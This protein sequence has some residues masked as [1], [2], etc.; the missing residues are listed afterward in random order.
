MSN[1]ARLAT[2][3]FNRYRP[4]HAA[5]GRSGHQSASYDIF[6]PSEA[7]KL[8][9][10]LS[11]RPADAPSPH[12][13]RL[14]V[15]FVVTLVPLKLLRRLPWPSPAAPMALHSQRAVSQDVGFAFPSKRV[16]SL[17]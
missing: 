10:L 3:T 14:P 15:T 5:G 13:C 16:T 9:Q 17:A 2:P 1:C 11:S 7:P 8:Y 6:V 4:V 12:N